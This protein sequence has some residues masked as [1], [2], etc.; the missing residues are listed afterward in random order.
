MENNKST[1]QKISESSI[2]KNILKNAEEYLKKPL[3]VK[4][5]LN[6]AY[7]KASQKKDV[8]TLAHEV[9]ES[10]QT[11]SRMIKAAVTGEYT[12]IPTST[13]VGGIAVI[14]YFLSPIDFVPDFI[15]VIGLLDD[16]ALLA[17]FM[18]GIKS[19]MDKFEEWERG[20]QVQTVQNA[21][22][23]SSQ[24]VDTSNTTPKYG[25]P[26]NNY[27]STPNAHNAT[28]Q[29][30]G[31]SQTINPENSTSSQK[32]NEDGT[33][34]ND[35]E[36]LGV[37]EFTPHDLQTESNTPDD[38]AI[39]ATSSG[40]GEPNVRAATTDSTRIP[41]SNDADSRAGGNVR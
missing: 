23:S 27:A 34:K 40:A 3:R 33:L 26:E 11:L 25:S 24:P 4:K 35:A 39:R 22:V 16:A 2:F 20:N 8:G 12:G 29:S 31:S 38:S 18:T 30:V 37:K 5:L 9:W 14:L 19:E 15:P 10:L 36:K 32:R 1:G 21:V 7:T 17:W 28:N 6:D 13:V 41:S